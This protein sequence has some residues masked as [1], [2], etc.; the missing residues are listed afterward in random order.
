M[1]GSSKRRRGSSRKGAS[2]PKKRSLSRYRS[3][4]VRTRKHYSARKRYRMSA[5]S[6]SRS[7]AVQR[8]VGS[9]RA[10]RMSGGSGVTVIKHREYIMDIY[11][12]SAF[13]V[14][15]L[16]INPGTL[17]TFPWLS[18]LAANYTTYKFRK[19]NFEFVS[20]CG[21]AVSSTNSALGTVILAV[22]YNVNQISYPNKQSMESADY[23]VSGKP[24]V[25]S[26]CHVDTNHI[27][28]SGQPKYIRTGLVTTGTVS[29]ARW[30]DIGEIG[31]GTV[32]AQASFACGELWVNY[33]VELYQPQLIASLGE[34]LLST[35]FYNR[36]YGVASK[37]DAGA[38]FASSSAKPGYFYYNDIG[39]TFGLNT[40]T[41]PVGLSGIF[42][43]LFV[44]T[45]NANDTNSFYYAG[46]STAGSV[47]NTNLNV[48]S[49][50]TTS[51]LVSEFAA[52][53]GAVVAVV[54]GSGAC[55]QFHSFRRFQITNPNVAMV[56]AYTVNGGTSANTFSCD[57]II[58][59]VASNS[60]TYSPN[61]YFT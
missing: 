46:I 22:D 14:T 56:L 44:G 18:S 28:I 16:A 32:G 11:C 24:S 19:L 17:A 10:P 21:D 40:I 60:I 50:A 61:I 20:T 25:N 54:G 37:C 3:G 12:Q 31:I 59:Q 53:G 36:S 47:N 39:V 51:S 42:E 30:Y 2:S 45:M 8:L 29:D 1:H 57:V 38:P 52:P 34:N 4:R 6:T 7:S 35:H 48:G 15:T 23:A 27:M 26:V 9:K 55:N 13:N 43:V 49:G 58:N 5:G 41:F 33:E